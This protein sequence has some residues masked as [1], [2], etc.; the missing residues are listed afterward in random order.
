MPT[1]TIDQLSEREAL[2]LAQSVKT[3]LE[4]H[5]AIRDSFPGI[6]RFQHRALLLDIAARLVTDID[7]SACQLVPVDALERVQETATR[8]Q[9]AAGRCWIDDRVRHA[10][11]QHAHALTT[12]HRAA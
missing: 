2:V 6:P 11:E 5:D 12:L 3:L 1:T 4:L 8:L 9:D 7:P 10:L